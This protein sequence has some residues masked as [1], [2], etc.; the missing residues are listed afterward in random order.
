MKALVY[1]QPGE[2]QLQER[3]LP[4][5]VP[6]ELPAE[7]VILPAPLPAQPDPLQEKIDQILSNEPA[8]APAQPA[9]SDVARLAAMLRGA[10][11]AVI[12]NRRVEELAQRRA[13]MLARGAGRNLGRELLRNPLILATLGGLAFNFLGGDLP[14]PVWTVLKRLGAAS[15]ALG[16]I[17][18][19]GFAVALLLF[20][21]LAAAAR[22]GQ[23]LGNDQFAHQFN[24]R[25][26]TLLLE[27]A[28]RSTALPK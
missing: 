18:V 7:E 5:L 17:T 28:A 15:L 21:G 26:A 27:R 14:E 11:D 9:P 2:L 25:R 8:P 12:A 23:R 24:S 16:L 20:A 22:R 1:T 10:I 4:E 3:P 19:G 13:A 6:E